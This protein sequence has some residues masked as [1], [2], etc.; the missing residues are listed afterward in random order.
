MARRSADPFGR[1]VR[2]DR[3]CISRPVDATWN[4]HERLRVSPHAVLADVETFHLLARR[5]AEAD[6]LLD[7]PEERIAEDEDGREGNPDRDRLCSQLAEAAGIEETALAYA[8]ELGQRRHSE[9]AAAERAPDAGQAV[10]WQ[11]AH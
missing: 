4:R 8:V 11:R 7:D 5:H 3:R 6:R 1:P 9:Q 10:R 2:V